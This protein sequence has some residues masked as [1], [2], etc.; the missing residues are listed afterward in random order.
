MHHTGYAQESLMDF[1]TLLRLLNTIAN[2]ATAIGLFVLVYIQ[3][4]GRRRG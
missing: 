1:D 2:Y 3:T 4:R